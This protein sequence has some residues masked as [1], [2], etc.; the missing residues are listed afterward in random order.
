M[1][2]LFEKSTLATDLSIQE[3]RIH[4]IEEVQKTPEYKKLDSVRK[5]YLELELETRSFLS[6]VIARRLEVESRE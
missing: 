2:S 5:D 6:L 1:T 3:E 4:L